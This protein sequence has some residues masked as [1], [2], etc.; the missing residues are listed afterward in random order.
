MTAMP[1][2]ARGWPL[3]LSEH[4]SANAAAP[5]ETNTSWH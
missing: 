5:P 1:A 4:C 2:D 3:Q